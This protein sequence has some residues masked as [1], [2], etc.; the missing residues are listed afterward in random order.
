MFGA[1]LSPDGHTVA[2]SSPVGGITQVFVML[3]SGGDPLQLTR[4]DGDK[5]VDSF[6][7][8]G[9]EIY[10]G[11]SLG[12]DEGWAIATLLGVPRR[13][14]SG[15]ELVPTI[16]GSGIFFVPWYPM[17]VFRVLKS[18]V[19]EEEIFNFTQN[20]PEVHYGWLLPFPNNT[21]VLVD[22]LPTP[23]HYYKFNIQSRSATDL[24]LSQTVSQARRGSSRAR[25]WSSAGRSMVGRTSG[26]TT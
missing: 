15:R 12:R 16:D 8:D 21:D 3:T 4:D 22:T 1:K 5:F 25:P 13:V 6:S 26:R 17:S 11:R 9:A 19:G 20:F 10:Y 23:G 14:A 2:F 24:G 18:G 7:A